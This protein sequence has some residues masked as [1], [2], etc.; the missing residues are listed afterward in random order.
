MSTWYRSCTGLRNKCT[1]SL[2]IFLL[3]NKSW[4]LWLSCCLDSCISRVKCTQT[5]FI[6]RCIIYMVNSGGTFSLPCSELAT[7]YWVSFGPSCIPPKTNPSV[8]KHKMFRPHWTLFCTWLVC[9]LSCLTFLTTVHTWLCTH[10]AI[11]RCH[12]PFLCADVRKFM[13]GHMYGFTIVS[14]RVE[15]VYS[16]TFCFNPVYY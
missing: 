7:D 4:C 16:L 11:K 9:T 3:L 15:Y 1:Y 6:C 2:C 5:Q 10:L 8:P 13:L 14:S 12:W